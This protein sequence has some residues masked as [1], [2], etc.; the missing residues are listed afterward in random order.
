MRASGP[1]VITCF[2]VRLSFAQDLS[3]IT[4]INNPFKPFVRIVPVLDESGKAFL[5]FQ[6]GAHHVVKINS[7]YLT[8]RKKQSRIALGREVAPAETF[9]IEITPELNALFDS[10]SDGEQSKRLQIFLALQPSPRGQKPIQ[11]EARVH[12]GRVTYFSEVRAS[13]SR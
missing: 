12:K 13:E 8:H 7:V 2:V 6:N 3:I 4:P 1:I 10:A 9:V 5:E 11:V